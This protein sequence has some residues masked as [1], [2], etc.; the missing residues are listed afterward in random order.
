MK[1]NITVRCQYIEEINPWDGGHIEVDLCNVDTDDVF[2]SLDMDASDVLEM[3]DLT[4][5]YD[6]LDIDDVM[7]SF[8]LKKI[9]E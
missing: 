7:A 8:D 4:D 1:R 3:M 6:W 5:I 2:E 9:G